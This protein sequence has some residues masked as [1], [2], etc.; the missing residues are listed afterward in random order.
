V[1]LLDQHRAVGEAAALAI[2]GA[3]AGRRVDLVQLARPGAGAGRDGPCA[4]EL[5]GLTIT[6]RDVQVAPGH[7][8]RPP[9]VRP[10]APL[11]A[12][13]GCRRPMTGAP[14]PQGRRR[15]PLQDERCERRS[16]RRPSP[17]RRASTHSDQ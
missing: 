3:G 14:G 17:S 10:S 5:V 11:A 4:Q 15:P 2:G 16:W 8:R 12:R 6:G 13:S 9:P 1:D 7:P